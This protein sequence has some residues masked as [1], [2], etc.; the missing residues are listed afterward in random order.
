[1]D[2][3]G[4]TILVTG[5][6][7][8]IG[9]ETAQLASRLGGC[10]VLSG[11]HPDRLAGVRNDLAGSGHLVAPLDLMADTDV[12]AWMQSVVAE[13]GPLDGL[14]HS[15]G[16]HKVRPLRVMAPDLMPDMFR[17]NVFAA[18]EL[19]RA[20]RRPSIRRGGGSVVFLSSVLGS[21]GQAGLAAYSASKGA[22][23]TLCR[24]LALELAR[25]HIRVNCVAPGMV[26][27]EM[28][29]ALAEQVVPGEMERFAALHPLGL[30]QPADVANAICFLLADTGRWITGSVL[31]VDGGYTAH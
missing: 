6:S 14:V 20:F 7:S 21:V 15:A 27:T 11:R 23:T 1:M 19:T 25:E 29:D 3:T 12:G 26:A 4:R 10:V 8:G 28:T 30:G 16:V 13:V 31:A 17:V 24:S 5:A 9:R 2:L 22:L 18:A